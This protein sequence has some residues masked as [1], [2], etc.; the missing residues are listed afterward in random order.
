MTYLSIISLAC[1][2]LQISGLFMIIFVDHLPPFF[3]VFVGITGL[4]AVV[5]IFLPLPNHQSSTAICGAV[6]GAGIVILSVM[7]HPTAV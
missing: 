6:V 7:L 3:W 1:T 2:F 4:A 5:K